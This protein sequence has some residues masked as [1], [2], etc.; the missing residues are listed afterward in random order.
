M[1]KERAANTKTVYILE[2]EINLES[3]RSE[4]P[5]GK[6]KCSSLSG[7]RN[8]F[9]PKED[10]EPYGKQIRIEGRLRNLT[11]ACHP[12]PMPAATRPL[13]GYGTF[14]WKAFSCVHWVTC[15][16]ETA[17]CGI[18]MWSSLVTYK[19]TLLYVQPDGNNFKGVTSVQTTELKQYPQRSHRAKIT[20]K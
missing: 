20:K 11:K 15:D 4:T 1:Q 14:S 5:K 8:P 18:D 9:L 19:E 10:L 3:Q 12:Y 6:G 2:E 13:E 16:I 7:L 17:I